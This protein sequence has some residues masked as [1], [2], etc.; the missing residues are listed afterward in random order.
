M[1]EI[2]QARKEQGLSLYKTLYEDEGIHITGVHTVYGWELHCIMDKCVKKNWR[3]RQHILRAL[4]DDSYCYAD[5]K[6][7]QLINF[8]HR[9][10][11]K[12]RFKKW[13]GIGK[14][15]SIWTIKEEYPIC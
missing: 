1:N 2:N 9:L 11:A 10:G 7:K 5:T 15:V 3:N 12:Q 8:L 6:N 13:L 4:P 14:S